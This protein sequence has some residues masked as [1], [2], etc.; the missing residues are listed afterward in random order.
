MQVC[1][2]GHSE[3]SPVLNKAVKKAKVNIS[4]SRVR[5]R[6]LSSFAPVFAGMLA[7]S[8]VCVAQTFE[9]QGQK[10]QPAPQTA[11]K[12]GTKS[13]QKG[14]KAAAPEQK[15]GNPFAWGTSI[16]VA[17]QARAAEDALRRGNYADAANYA[18][19]AANAAPQETRLWLLAGYANRLAGR[20]Q[21]SVDSFKHGLQNDPNSV[22]GLSS[23][24][25]TYSKMGNFNEAKELLLRVIALNPKRANDL[26]VA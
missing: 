8:T 21:A 2:P 5:V 26:A 12:S 11:P 4:S 3:S 14:A 6:L 16:D 9:I 22:E 20:N 15:S 7:L 13:S 24:A 17:R 19:H 23:L 1:T 18:T 10:P 25:Q